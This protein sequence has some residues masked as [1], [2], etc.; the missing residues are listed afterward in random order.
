VLPPA[1]WKFNWTHQERIP[2]SQT[3][4]RKG[5]AGV[6]SGSVQVAT[7]GRSLLRESS[8]CTIRGRPAAAEIDRLPGPAYSG[9]M[10]RNGRQSLREGANGSRRVAES[11]KSIP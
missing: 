11:S 10:T 8:E 7:A 5:S 6:W 3:R 2:F 1:R 9:D 4:A